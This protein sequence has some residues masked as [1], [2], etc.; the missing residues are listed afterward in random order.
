MMSSIRVSTFHPAGSFKLPQKLCLFR[1]QGGGGPP[2]V[3]DFYLLKESFFLGIH[4]APSQEGGI[5]LP[6]LFK[7]Y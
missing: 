1:T 3:S 2:S 7:G 4:C 5:Q 6:C